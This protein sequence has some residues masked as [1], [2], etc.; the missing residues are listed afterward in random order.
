MHEAV[1]LL[2]AISPRASVAMVS[3]VRRLAARAKKRLI[4][5]I[6]PFMLQ[7]SCYYDKSHSSVSKSEGNCRFVQKLISPT[8]WYPKSRVGCIL[9]I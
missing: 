6:A 7:V 5:I 8:A 4:A 2:V 9:L 3:I 1:A